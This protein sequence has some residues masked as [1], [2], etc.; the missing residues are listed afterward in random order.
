MFYG[1]SIQL[2]FS[3]LAGMEI[4]FDLLSHRLQQN[5]KPGYLD[6]ASG[7]ARAGSH[8][9]QHDK[10]RSGHLRPHIKICRGKTGSG[11]N[12]CY[13]KGRLLQRL[14]KT[15]IKHP[16]IPG[17]QKHSCAYGDQIPF[18]LLTF[19]RLFP[20]FCQNKKINIKVY[21]EKNHENSHNH[22]NI[23]GIAGDTVIFNTKSPRSRCTKCSGKRIKQRHPARQQKNNLHDSHKNVNAV[24]SLCRGTHR[25]GKT[26]DRRSRALRLHQIHM[27]TAR[28]FQQRKQKDQNSHTANPVGKTSPKQ[29]TFWQR[30]HLTEHTGSRCGKS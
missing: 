13:L 16:N 4:L 23:S 14:P 2:D 30:F 6:T 7:T 11:D 29:D 20:F 1:F 22:L 8:K 5:H 15:S 25:R 3:Y 10:N 21:S 18:Q 12:G 19:Q 24:Q 26:S 27:R 28:Q 9:H 17:N